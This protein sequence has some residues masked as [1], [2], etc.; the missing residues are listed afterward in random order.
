MDGI[1]CHPLSPAR[2]R[3]GVENAL[4]P[5]K[6]AWDENARGFGKVLHE[7]S[8]SMKLFPMPLSSLGEGHPD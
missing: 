5:L 2:I 1:I 8:A 7:Y 4:S 6:K 3:D